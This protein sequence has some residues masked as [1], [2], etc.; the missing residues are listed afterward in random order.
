MRLLFSFLALVFF[1]CGGEKNS[2]AEK[3]DASKDGMNHTPAPADKGI[4]GIV[5]VPEMLCLSIKDTA[6][7]ENISRK[8][9][10]DY[11]ALQEDIL[12]LNISGSGNPG[13]LLYTDHPKNII[14]RCLIPVPQM[15]AAKPSRSDLFVLEGT[16]AVVYN[17]Y[18]PYQNMPSAYEDIKKYITE[19]KLQ[20]TGPVREFYITDPYLEKDTSRWLSKIYIPVK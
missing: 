16:R 15:P 19:H 18:G 4:Q 6:T 17:Y 14:F 20:Q 7:G 12:A 11:Q 8:M 1:S 3:E 2:I 9:D 10:M 5:S 13:L